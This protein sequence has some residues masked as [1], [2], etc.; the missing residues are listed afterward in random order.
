MVVDGLVFFVDDDDDLIVFSRPAASRTTV[1]LEFLIF[2]SSAILASSRVCRVS[3]F[4]GRTERAEEMRPT[5]VNF[6]FESACCSDVYTS[7]SC[8]LDILTSKVSSCMHSFALPH[9]APPPFCSIGMTD[10]FADNTSGSSVDCGGRMI[11]IVG[12]AD[13]P[14][15]LS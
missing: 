4:F 12:D 11:E 15:A 8:S 13:E 7:V 2:S 14:E 1:L 10:P 3:S 5:N 9:N 6:A